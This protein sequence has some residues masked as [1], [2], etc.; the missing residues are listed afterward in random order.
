M[1]GHIRIFREM[2]LIISYV[3]LVLKNDF[4]YVIRRLP[5]IC[6]FFVWLGYIITDLRGIYIYIYTLLI[7]RDLF[8]TTNSTSAGLG[9]ARH[10]SPSVPPPFDRPPTMWATF[11]LPLL[12]FLSKTILS[13]LKFLAPEESLNSI[14]VLP[15]VG[16]DASQAPK[17]DGLELK[18]SSSTR[19]RGVRLCAIVAARVVRWCDRP[20]ADFYPKK[21]RRGNACRQPV[22]GESI[23]RSELRKWGQDWISLGPIC[24]RRYAWSWWFTSSAMHACRLTS[25]V[26]VHVSFL[27][28]W[29]VWC[30]RLMV[31]S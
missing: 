31:I 30:W 29:W 12:F 3:I 19:V 10:P 27:M 24:T 5:N 2:F 14:V 23:R 17:D 22:V 18:N 11:S 20:L 7:S 6:L 8:L 28:P 13:N 21:S 1:R 15:Q 16:R 9:G 4:T 26:C 25:K